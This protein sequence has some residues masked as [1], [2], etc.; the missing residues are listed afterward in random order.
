MKKQS[1]NVLSSSV[2]FGLIFSAI[3][4]GILLP[5]VANADSVIATIPVGAQPYGDVYDP[6]NGDIYVATSTNI[7]KV[8]S[9]ST[10]KVIA[11]ITEPN[12]SASRELAY[13][14]ANGYI[15][16]ANADAGTV[17]V[18]DG[19]TNRYVTTINIPCD[20]CRYP[21]PDGVAYDSANRDIYVANAGGFYDGS[22]VR[23][24]VSVID[25]STNSLINTIHLSNTN[26]I[27][28]TYDPA[29]GYIYVVDV[30][31]GVSV[32]DGS[33]N[34]VVKIINGVASPVQ[35][36]YDP[37]NGYLYTA[38]HTSNVVSVIDT[39]TNTLVAT[40][41]GLKDPTGVGYSPVN[42]HIYVPNQGSN[43]V[44]IINTTTNRVISNVTVGSGPINPAFDSANGDMYVTNIGGS[45][46]VIATQHSTTLRL[47]SIA[48]VPW[49]T[50]ATVTGRLTDNDA[51]NV[52]IGGKTLTFT[53]TGADSL[54]SA[55]TNPDGTFTAS[56]LAPNT[57]NS[58]W[59]VQAHFAGDSSFGGSSSSVQ[60]YNTVIHTTT[61][62]LN[63]I[64]SVAPTK[65][66]TVTGT[67]TDTV[68]GT[69]TGGK[70]ITFNGTGAGSIMAVTTHPDGTFTITGQ[71][72]STVNN[73]W[74]VQA[75]FAGYSLYAAADSNV[76]SY[77]TVSTTPTAT[78]LTLN[79][80]ANVPW[81]TTVKVTGKLAVA[82]S[83]T[84]IGG[85]NI[86]FTGTGASSMA[87][88]TTN[89]DGT[90]TASG[91]SPNTV[92]T[93]WTVQAHFAGDSLYDAAKSPIRSYN[94]LKHITSLS[95]AIIPTSIPAHRP[96]AVS[97]TLLDTTKSQSLASK[98]ITF[99]ATSPILIGSKIT[100]TIGQYTA[101]GLISPST[102][103]TYNIQSHFAGDAL[104]SVASS[105]TQSLLVTTAQTQF[106]PS[107]AASSTNK[108][109]SSSSA[110]P[111]M[112][113]VPSGT[114]ISPPLNPAQRQLQQ[115]QTTTS[116]PSLM[117]PKFPYT[118][119]NR[120]PSQHPYLS[121]IP[122]SQPSQNTLPPVGNTGISQTVNENARVTLDGRAS[123]AANGGTVVTYQ[124]TQL[125]TGVAVIL[126]GSNTATPTFTAP[127]VYTDTVLAFSLRVLDNHGAL[128]TNP[129][130]VFVMVKHNP[131]NGGNV[132][133]TTI[134]QPH[135]QQQAIVPNNNAIS[136]PSLPQ[137]GSPT[138]P[139]SS[140]VK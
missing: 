33:T 73:G 20:G 136:R 14:P 127:V 58:G 36:V 133:G 89:T 86:A 130:V 118:Y 91:I 123:Y 81:S 116:S 120:Y 95:L 96:Y 77:N 121:Q 101:S 42:D 45:V 40:I 54:G 72:P 5:R 34:T 88:V 87:S 13:D 128:S 134:I 6:A 37:A 90:F 47:N 19:S 92:A 12:G 25:G 68:A 78:T 26:S 97:G 10:N 50:T 102:T 66:V 94:T 70:T 109:T 132:P 98:T 41:P 108:T 85:K 9:G 113:V 46:S 3:S 65:T 117:Q 104:Y 48:N 124:W 1:S 7:V 125:P 49:H 107:T 119:Q 16:V 38:G 28:D 60:N 137:I 59:T 82:S 69:G 4:S 79:A 64:T 17:G 126:T 2:L 135:Q 27:T 129:A 63:P 62:T 52:G 51:S 22:T 105:P 39:R 76:Q 32:I 61:L 99:T 18:I 8:I 24:T 15:Y 57:V 29:N 83:S 131:T 106:S 30:G 80:I 71:A 112:P 56:G 55:T 110:P 23:S 111:H 114:G 139:S 53:G 75:H 11:N 115:P 140:G 138:N 44:S 67:L 103:G 21:F 43:Y 122:Q 100:N 74:T 93:G 35:L 31:G 84:G